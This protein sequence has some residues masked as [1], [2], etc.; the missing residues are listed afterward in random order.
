KFDPGLGVLVQLVD[1]NQL[2]TTRLYDS[3]GRLGG[4][5]R[6]DGTKT[7]VTLART[8][9]GGPAQDAWRVTKRTAT[10]GGA[11]DTIE[12]DSR[13]RAVRWWWY[14]PSPGGAARPRIVQQIAYDA[15]GEHV[16]Q[17]SV[18]TSEGVAASGILYDRYQYDAAGR[19]VEHT[20]PWGALVQTAY[21]GATVQ[22]TDALGQVTVTEK[23]PL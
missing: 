3:F 4:E 9:D 19:E 14:G 11:D 21:T 1:P 12:Y 15:T 23:D 10:T 17:R 16:A 18:P 7:V 20:T 22:V 8:K 5:Q 13:S 2:V 6:P